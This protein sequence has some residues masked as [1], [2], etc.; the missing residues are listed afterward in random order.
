[1]S[2]SRRRQV[3]G[4]EK[5]FSLG[6]VTL[7]TVYNQDHFLKTHMVSLYG[8]Q[9]PD[10]K[11]PEHKLRR[12]DCLHIPEP[13]H[14]PYTKNQYVVDVYTQIKPVS[15]NEHLNFL[16][17]KGFVLP[18]IQVVAKA[19]FCPQRTIP[20]TYD[21]NWIAYIDRRPNLPVSKDQHPRFISLKRKENALFACITPDIPEQEV[22]AQDEMLFFAVSMVK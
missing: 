3:Y 16:G 22:Y 5:V 2:K 13:T 12:P 8:Y 20:A 17:D 11:N 18:G 6:V 9:Y 7:D 21:G 15:L 10:K 1:M 19:L 4:F 14:T